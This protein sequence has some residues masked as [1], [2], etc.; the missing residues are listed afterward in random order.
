MVKIT[1]KYYDKYEIQLYES[2][3]KVN[4]SKNIYMCNDLYIVLVTDLLQNEND[5]C[6]NENDFNLCLICKWI[7]CPTFIIIYQT[8]KYSNF[9]EN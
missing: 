8:E 9:N 5:F 4:F 3:R 1:C 7:M 2:L 6:M